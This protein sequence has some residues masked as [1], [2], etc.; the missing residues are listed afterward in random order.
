MSGAGTVPSAEAL[1]AGVD[2]PDGAPIAVAVSGGPD[3][4][5]LLHLAAEHGRLTGREVTAL[6]VDHGIRPEAA[7]EALQVAAWCAALGVPHYILASDAPAPAADI[8]AWARHL[9]YRLMGAWC[10]EQGV[11]AL[12]VAHSRDDQ[13]E[14]FLLRLGR[15]SG[16]DGLASM[17][18]DVTRDGLRILRPL[19]ATSREDLRAFLAERGQDFIQDPSNNDTRHAR[20][21]MRRLM[22][23][24][25]AEGMTAARLA[26]TAGRLAI[27]RDALDGWMRAH[28]R[29]SVRFFGTGHAVM[30]QAAFCDVPEDIGLRALAALVRGVGG[31]VY[32][33]R[34][35]HTTSLLARLREA[36]F[37]G[38][39]LGGLRFQA[40]GAEVLVCRE[41]RALAG[42]VRLRDGQFD[43]DGRF[44]VRVDH[45]AAESLQ[46]AAL[47]AANWRDIRHQPGLPQLPAMVGGSL[48]ALYREGELVDIPGF[49]T[50]D[51][52]GDLSARAVFVAPARAGLAAGPIA[53]GQA[54]P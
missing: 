50:P 24:L 17:A 35:A 41:G 44:S 45:A 27:A 11:A 22:P 53:T 21:R 30:D 10:R 47:G 34:L 3:S 20:V 29:A 52:A 25:A 2:L 32:R 36:G 4:M 7:E 43:W 9:R 38:A 6:T 28:V 49:S 31:G 33:P 51:R 1:L 16:V 54:K 26:E 18:R 5:A 37:K 8:Q 39:T 14:T 40:R 48:P 42:P 23:A 12:L 46:V 19:L 15:G 13:A